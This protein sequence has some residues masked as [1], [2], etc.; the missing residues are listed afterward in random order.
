[1]EIKDGWISYD[2]FEAIM[3]AEIDWR[4][5]RLDF[6]FVRCGFKD[7][8]MVQYPSS[9]PR[10]HVYLANTCDNNFFGRQKSF[11]KEVIFDFEN[12]VVREVSTK[13]D[14]RNVLI[15]YRGF[16]DDRYASLFQQPGSVE[17]E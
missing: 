15:D 10:E 2:E 17:T 9:I 7:N 16:R 1:L 12:S 8:A 11:G 3:R 6:V 4:K 14:L 5:E 13:W